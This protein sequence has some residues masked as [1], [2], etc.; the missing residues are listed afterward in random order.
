MDMGTITTFERVPGQAYSE[1]QGIMTTAGGE[2]AIYKTH[3]IGRFTG[4][5]GSMSVRFSAAF[6]AGGKLAALNGYLVVGETEIDADG[7]QTT[8]LWEWK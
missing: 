5:G 2:G 8:T 3:G 7:N 4:E 1:G 6:Q